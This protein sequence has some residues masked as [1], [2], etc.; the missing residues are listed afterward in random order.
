MK[1][2]ILLLCFLQLFLII[3]SQDD[4]IEE[5]LIRRSL[6][7]NDFNI[8]K[9]EII[10]LSDSLKEQSM[11]NLRF[12][13]YQG[14]L[15]DPYVLKNKVL[16]AYI[17]NLL[18]NF[19]NN[20]GHYNDAISTFET[21][22]K[23]LTSVT[24]SDD[25]NI[26]LGNIYMN[27]GNSF[28]YLAS[29][30]RSL[31]YYKK[32]LSYLNRMNK[33]NPK[34]KV[35]LG[36]IYNNLAISYTSKGD[37]KTG[38]F[39]FK[40]AYNIDRELKDSTRMF[41][42]QLNIATCFLNENEIDSA[43]LLYGEA[44]DYY[45]RNY[46]LASLSYVNSHIANTY[47]R[48][49]DFKNAL[50]FSKLAL[51]DVDSSQNKYELIDVY[52]TLRNTYDSIGDYKNALKY[53]KYVQII[54][55][56]INSA[57]VLNKIKRREIQMEFNS[58][59]YADS[60][61]NAEK[62]RV[63]DLSIDQKRKQNW[64]L[65]STMLLLLLLLFTLFTRFK[66]TKRQKLIIEEKEKI[67]KEQNI[68]IRQQKELVETKQKEIVD[69]I[70]YAKKIQTTL[71]AQT[72][73]L[74]ES[75]KEYFLFFNPKDIVSGD[76]YWA[77]KQDNRFYLA[78]CDS[79][80]HGVPGAFMSLLNI[81]FLN[82]AVKEKQIREPGKVLDFVRSRIC[83]NISKEG[84]KDGFDGTIICITDNEIEYASANSALIICREGNY[85]KLS[86]DRMPVGLGENMNPFNTYKIDVKA[87]DILYM[88]TDG[89]PDQFGGV[90]EESRLNGGK[91]FKYKAFNE[92]LC[93]SSQQSLDFQKA[94]IVKA[95]KDWKGELEQVD[96]VCV[97]GIKF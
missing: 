76:F 81:S 15:N 19:Y 39:Y 72:D 38:M 58:Q 65:V 77:A 11:H 60:L 47:L 85:T 9:D 70:N 69:S 59:R 51:K 43:L 48:K 36:L 46:D 7:S 66:A 8:Q 71:L 56:S 88:Y 22:I 42:V 97:L 45:Q 89:Y 82:E 57:E 41:N 55:D 87:G 37:S 84:Q 73:I 86:S 95:F 63:R 30:D 34:V 54:S 40:R 49:S 92:L 13:F 1:K 31:F 2:S 75:L 62:I 12:N 61:M 44:R 27:L 21:G 94:E 23:T 64:Y 18:G 83:E 67:T 96:D 78:V 26:I 25:A 74:N 24:S 10:K 32:S 91:K 50:Y 29:Y 14:L 16:K 68:V 20:I 93:K 28:F 80:G 90:T 33:S 79:I 4:N 35:R 3:K 53:Y 5:S 6:V 17:L 52:R